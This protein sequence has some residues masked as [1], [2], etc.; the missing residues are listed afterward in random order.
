MV[1]KTRAP[2]HRGLFA[3]EGMPAG[4]KMKN[5]PVALH[6]TPC[7]HPTGRR[8]HE[9]SKS[10]QKKHRICPG[11]LKRMR[12]PSPPSLPGTPGSSHLLRASPSATRLRMWELCLGV[13]WVCFLAGTRSWGGGALKGTPF[14]QGSACKPPRYAWTW[15]A[16][17]GNFKGS[18]LRRA[19]E[20]LKN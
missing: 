13:I 14:W 19:F 7:P 17:L 5:S 20:H 9:R 16:S 6:R 18:G 12:S 2:S 1:P 3:F 10:T 8:W 15:W 4:T 11:H